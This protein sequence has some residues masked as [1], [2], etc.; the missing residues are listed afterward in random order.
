[1][2]DNLK[3]LDGGVDNPTRDSIP[4]ESY[5]PAAL[6]PVLGSKMFGLSTLRVWTINKKVVRRFF[7]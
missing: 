5:I 6:S 2:F 4:V 3:C 7:N 1:M